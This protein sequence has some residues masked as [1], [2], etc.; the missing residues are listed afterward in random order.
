MDEKLIREIDFLL[1]SLKHHMDLF[2]AELREGY[3]EIA[4]NQLVR[5]TE[6]LTLIQDA[7]EKTKKASKTQKTAKK[8]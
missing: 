8:K 6:D 1:G 2:F 7:F 5:M 3:L 4:E